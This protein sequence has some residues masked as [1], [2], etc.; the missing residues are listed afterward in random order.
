MNFR[1][2]MY[3]TDIRE[4]EAIRY[5]GHNLRISF[6]ADSYLHTFASKLR[7]LFIA[8]NFHPLF[9]NLYVQH[10]LI[11]FLLIKRMTLD[12]YRN[13][14]LCSFTQFCK[15]LHWLLISYKIITLCFTGWYLRFWNL[16]NFEGDLCS[17]KW[18]STRWSNY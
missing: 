14:W 15:I 4:R 2:G 8:A 13:F 16:I 10:P 18:N 6:N 7:F 12:F 1:C 17:R 9:L 3:S 5:L 11:Y